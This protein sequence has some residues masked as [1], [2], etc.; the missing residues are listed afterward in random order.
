MASS[1]SDLYDS[2]FSR[3]KR[4]FEDGDRKG[5]SPISGF[6]GVS[7]DEG[8]RAFG[9]AAEGNALT[10]ATGADSA[11]RGA[12]VVA[13]GLANERSATNQALIG[14]VGNAFSAM[15]QPRRGEDSGGGLL[16]TGLSIAGSFVNPL[17]GA[18]ARTAIKGFG[19]G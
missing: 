6:A 14:A 3:A 16:D 17:L 12:A 7:S 19:L 10:F 9:K 11:P 5:A 13:G 8:S 18:A 1:A 2:A 15:N 4:S